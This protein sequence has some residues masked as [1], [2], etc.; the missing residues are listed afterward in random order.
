M[1]STPIDMG[2]LKEQVNRL[3]QLRAKLSNAM[4]HQFQG[5]DQKSSLTGKMENFFSQSDNL[6]VGGDE[7]VKENKMAADPTLLPLIKLANVIYLLEIKDPVIFQKILDMFDQQFQKQE[8][9]EKIT[10]AIRIVTMAQKIIIQGSLLEK[11]MP[12]LLER[13]VFYLKRNDASELDAFIKEADGFKAMLEYEKALSEIARKDHELFKKGQAYLIEYRRAHQNNLNDFYDI[14]K[15][16]LEMSTKIINELNAFYQ[17]VANDKEVRS[18]TS[19]ELIDY[20]KKQAE[21]ADMLGALFQS[22]AK[23]ANQPIVKEGAVQEEVIPESLKTLK[24]IYQSI[25]YRKEGVR[26]LIECERVLRQHKV[27]LA[28]NDDFILGKMEKLQKKFNHVLDAHY[29][30]DQSRQ[31][32][33]KRF[34]NDVNDSTGLVQGFYKFHERLQEIQ[35][36]SDL[37][38]ANEIKT[39]DKKSIYDEIMTRDA[40]MVKQVIKTGHGIQ[41][42]RSEIFNHQKAAEA[43]HDYEIALY[44]I[45]DDKSLIFKNRQTLF[46]QQQ[47]QLK[48]LL[49]KNENLDNFIELLTQEK[50]ALIRLEALHKELN[51]PTHTDH[52]VKAKGEKVYKDCD[53]RLYDQFKKPAPNIEDIK[54]I[55]K[56]CLKNAIGAV[57]H[58]GTDKAKPFVTGLLKAAQKAL[59]KPSFGR[60]F[61][62]GLIFLA[63]AVVIGLSIAGIPFT[64]GTSALIGVGVAA[65]FGAA[66]GVSGMQWRQSKA[67]YELGTLS[68]TKLPGYKSFWSSFRRAADKPQPE[69]KEIPEIINSTLDEIQDKLYKN[70][71]GALKEAFNNYVA[72]ARD[73]ASID[74]KGFLPNLRNDSYLI[75][76]LVTSS[77][78][79]VKLEVLDQLCKAIQEDS[80]VNKRDY[81]YMKVITPFIALFVLEEMF[82]KKGNI[83]DAGV[84]A[85]AFVSHE[86]EK[87]LKLA[88]LLIIAAQSA[89]PDC[90]KAALAEKANNITDKEFNI[91]REQVLGKLKPTIELRR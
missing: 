62:G 86:P 70:E 36:K 44:D 34:L 23:K 57:K 75:S 54:F 11:D 53:E 55:H 2:D 7:A 15:S 74:D 18:I 65:L 25:L 88:S 8:N 69:K 46:N 51:D 79:K 78:S 31:D 3:R 80:N 61:A 67:L 56:K 29:S 21:Y 5:S 13:L 20:D 28:I 48:E 4:L 6:I 1:R 47:E 63:S 58:Q 52:K 33:I 40:A 37:L 50:E 83:Y 27:I 89:E 12:I 73:R 39:Q 71:S 84:A 41:T 72:E 68:E 82:E 24:K 59:G 66:L 26:D 19:F 10:E 32:A 60:K 85:Y 22:Y 9:I 17:M 35:R 42:T 38:H 49:D 16:A 91:L 30:S 14:L 76:K 81:T 64:L 45:T 77:D 43:L 87:L 90:D